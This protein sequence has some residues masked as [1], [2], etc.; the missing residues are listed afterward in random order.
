MYIK[1]NSNYISPSKLDCF[2]PQIHNK[3][4]GTTKGKLMTESREK[5]D[6][7]SSSKGKIKSVYSS[8]KNSLKTQGELYERVPSSSMET[9]LKKAKPSTSISKRVN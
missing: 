6:Y 5:E 7:Y 1:N 3:K 2:D 4:F 9:K 8:K